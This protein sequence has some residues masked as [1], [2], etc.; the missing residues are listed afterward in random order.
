MKNYLENKIQFPFLLAGPLLWGVP[1]PLG[2][3]P[4]TL[5]APLTPLHC[6]KLGYVSL[7]DNENFRIEGPSGKG[8]HAPWLRGLYV[9]PGIYYHSFKSTPV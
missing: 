7:S 5:G 9:A 6:F 2:P 3:P 8:P 1:G 4:S